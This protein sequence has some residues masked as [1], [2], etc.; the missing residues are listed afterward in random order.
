[1]NKL[2]L[3]G[4]SMVTLLSAMGCGGAGPS[5]TNSSGNAPAAA[6]PMETGSIPAL[7]SV[8]IRGL[9]HATNG[10]SLPRV[11]VC[12]EDS[13]TCGTSGDDGS[14]TLS[15][16]PANQ[17]VPVTFRKDGFLS[18]LRVIQTQ[19]S[20]VVVEMSELTSPA[21]PPQTFM[22]AAIDPDKGNIAFFVVSPDQQPAPG[23]WVTMLGTG[24]SA[25]TY[26]GAD[27]SPDLDA[28]EGSTGGFV[29]VPAGLY[30][31]QF[32]HPGATCTA[33][34]LGGYPLTVGQQ[35]GDVTLI[36]PVVAGYV[37]TSVSVSC[38]STQ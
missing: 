12:L 5:D 18:L 23:V 27:G 17:F 29:N 37:T 36:V 19:T 8:S 1:M 16:A 33:S 32:G 30:L 13:S 4:A 11:S 6:S 20:D 28:T 22:G 34:D 10:T 35:A 14:F 15:G 25:P 31:L 7:P 3:T 21:V 26:L 24:A 38:V 2:T 9:I